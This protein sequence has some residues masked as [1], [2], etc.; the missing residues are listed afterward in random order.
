MVVNDDMDGSTN[1]EIFDISK[2]HSFINHT[3][4]C[5]RGIAV[6]QNRNTVSNIFGTFWVKFDIVEEQKSAKEK[7]EQKKRNE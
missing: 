4:S 1:R 7:K 2:L 5:E 3:L 6:K